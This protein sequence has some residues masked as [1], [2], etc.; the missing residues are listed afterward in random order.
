MGDSPKFQ[1][2]INEII[3]TFVLSGIVGILFWVWTFVWEFFSPF[4]KAVG[5]NYLF[6]GFWMI[7]GL[8]PAFII[9]KPGIAFI[10]EVF[11]AFIELLI[12]QW[13]LSAIIWGVVQGIAAEVAF[14]IFLYKKWNFFTIEIAGM[15][16]TLASYAL[17]FFYSKYYALSSTI[18]L[19]QI[20][21]AAISGLVLAGG[22][23][24]FL[25]IALKNTGVLSRYK[26]AK[27]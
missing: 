14:S 17:D 26:I 8:I 4:L 25:T 24:Y 10:G 18:I 5:A 1:L 6:V 2:K 21:C 3:L 13:G 20:I 19:V 16:S 11:A 22:L 9:R 12:T 15:F 7:G 23:S 27:E